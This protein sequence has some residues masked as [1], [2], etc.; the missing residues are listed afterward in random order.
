MPNPRKKTGTDWERKIADIFNEYFDTNV[1]KRIPG[2]GAIGTILSISELLGDVKGKFDFTNL[3]I[4]IEA[5]TGYGG[6]K[7]FVIKKEWLDKIKEE[8]N[9]SFGI[10]LLAGKFLGAKQGVKHFIVLDIYD[11][12]KLMDIA[13]DLKEELD[14]L[15]YE[16]EQGRKGNRYV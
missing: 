12:L 8:A 16:L 11:F 2:S 13:N 6:S 1:W 4:F 5:K 15:H 14:N 9:T 3:P 10:G 7:Q